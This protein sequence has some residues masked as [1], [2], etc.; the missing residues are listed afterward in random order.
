MTQ[1]AKNWI[2]DGLIDYEYKK[3]QLLAYLQGVNQQFSANRLYPFL[4]DLIA[5][6]R[7]LNQFKFN[8]SEMSALFP[9]DLH[10]ID[11]QKRV[12]NYKSKIG[13]D[14]LMNELSLITEYAL[15]QM[16]GQIK[17]GKEIYDLVELQLEFEPVGIVPIYKRE[18][19]VLFSRESKNDILAYRYKADLLQYAGE[20]FRM[21]KMWLVN[22]FQQSLV[23]TLEK[24]K[25]EL[26]K[27]IKEL[28]NP[29]TWRIHSKQDF[30]LEETIIP[31]SKRLLIKTV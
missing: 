9:K 29:A 7:E 8:K 4:G 20:K 17:A 25:M 5:H 10:S 31:I 24:I 14:D 28:P 23:N 21:I 13:D 26:V 18:G 16:N 22:V 11:W 1:L 3:Y 2:T 30:P 12:L 27:E 6:H 19:Y 15:S